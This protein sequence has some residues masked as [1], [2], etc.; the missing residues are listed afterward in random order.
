[1]VGPRIE[2]KWSA[3]GFYWELIDEDD[4]ALARSTMN[5]QAIERCEGH[6]WR[7]IALCRHPSI[8]VRVTGEP[9]Q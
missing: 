8:P 1:M 6:A 4:R 3:D 5:Y 7:V 2:V 9:S